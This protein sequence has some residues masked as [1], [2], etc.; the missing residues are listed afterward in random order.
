M[1]RGIF[2]RVAEV[3]RLR[4]SLSEDFYTELE[5]A[6]V[7]SDVS[8]KTALGLAEYLRAETKAQGITDVDAARELLKARLVQ[9]LTKSKSNLVWPTTPPGLFLIVGVNGTGKTTTIAKLAYRAK[10]EGRKVLLAAGDTFRAAAGEQLEIWSQRLDIPIVM[11]RFGGDPAAV[12]FDSLEAASAR[13]M[14]LVVADTAGRLHTKK[15]LMEELK[16]IHRVS[17]EKLGREPEEV[18]LVV[19]ATT[20]QNALVQAQEFLQAT[21]ITGLILTKLDSTAKGGIV[22][23]IADEL[24]L[25]IKCIGTGEKPEDL[26]DFNPREFVDALLGDVGVEGE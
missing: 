7:S 5:E 8:V 26:E 13:G 12:I 14:E 4:R 10:R 2:K 18:L 24:G 19:D 16:K 22:I 6:L 1:L 11:G 21:N 17:K 3:F 15:N 25:P 20:G 9:I 23:T